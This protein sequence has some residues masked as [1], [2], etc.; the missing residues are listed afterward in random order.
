VL[1]TAFGV[2]VLVGNTIVVGILRTTG[3]VAGHLPST[4]L[5][6]GVWVVGGLYAVLGAMSLAEPGA[7]V[8]R[9]G[10]QYAIVHRALGPYPG[11]I[12]GWSDWLSTAASLALAAIVFAEYSAPLLP[13][14]PGQVQIISATLVIGFGLLQWRGI[15]SG[16]V[17][18][19]LL[20]ALKALA[21]GALI[22][23][24]LVMAVP[25]RVA[26][27]A[28]T[29]PAGAGMLAAVI[30]GLQAVIFSFDGWTGPIYFGEETVDAGRTIPRAMIVGVLV[31]LA[32]YLLYNLAMVRVL[33]VEAMAGDPFVAATASS[34]LFGNRGDLVVR[35]LVLLSLLGGANAMLLMAGRVPLAM[36]RDGLMP[37]RFDSV[38]VGGTPTVAHW[39]S[40]G[41]A[42][43]FILTGTFNTVLALAAFFFVANYVLSFASVFALRR[44]EPDTPR[45]FRVPGFPWTTGLV[46]LGSVAFIVGSIMSD[47]TNSLRSVV[48]LAASY[49]IYRLVLRLRG[50]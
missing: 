40:V 25:E 26:E 5:F 4:A 21:F 38:N 47:R 31:V 15:Q 20:S 28:V 41:L 44:N 19:Q 14:F 29:I 30:L 35:L 42:L 2:A 48:L 10:G 8:Q 13:A 16:D 3:E 6:L 23:A 50:K 33:G 18:Q 49:P 39:T 34:V 22:V 7:I 43:G 37:A 27:S 46:L 12:V 1:G 45:P 11:F 24:A 36:S 17:A 9:S 32:I